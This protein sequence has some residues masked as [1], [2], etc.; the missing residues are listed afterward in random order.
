MVRILHA[1][2]GRLRLRFEALKGRPDLASRLHRD[3]EAVSHMRRVEIDTRTGSVLLQFDPG[4]LKSAAFLNELS[5]ALGS[6]F[7]DHFAPGWLCFTSNR[8]KGNRALARRVEQH[9]SGVHGIERIEIDPST[10]KCLLIYDP[11]VV[12]SPGFRASLGSPLKLLMPKLDARRLLS[13]L[14]LG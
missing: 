3:L 10:G 5:E 7:P 9:L 11:E 4:A 12:T 8:L 14:G 13:R 2:P 6:Q 1:I